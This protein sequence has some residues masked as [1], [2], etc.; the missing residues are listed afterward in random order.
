MQENDASSASRFGD[1]GEDGAVSWN[2]GIACVAELSFGDVIGPEVAVVVRD[3]AIV[4]GAP[5]IGQKLESS[6]II[7]PHV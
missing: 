3:F 1:L 4:V 7:L 5:Q 2:T 6:G